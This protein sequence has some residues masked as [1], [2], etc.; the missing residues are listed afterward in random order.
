[1]ISDQCRTNAARIAW[2]SI[3]HP[4]MHGGFVCHALGLCGM[5][6]RPDVARNGS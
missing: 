2:S 6:S 3:A 1:L 5:V 4:L